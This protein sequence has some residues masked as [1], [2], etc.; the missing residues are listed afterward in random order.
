MAIIQTHPKSIDEILDIINI[1]DDIVLGL[2]NAFKVSYFK[3]YIELAVSDQWTT[4]DIDNISVNAYDY[5]QSHAGAFLLNRQ[6]WN[7]VSSV[8]MVPLVNNGIKTK[9]F[10]AL[11]EMLYFK[12]AAVLRAVLK[13]NLPSL[14]P[15]IT[16]ELM[17]ASLDASTK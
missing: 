7:L 16:F 17:N 3:E 12:E 10:K 11:S 9:Q 15:N 13:K 6:T 4:L 14:Y 1:S 5:P 2:R 8:I